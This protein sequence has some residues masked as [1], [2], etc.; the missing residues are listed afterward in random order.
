MWKTG[1]NLSSLRGNE[2][3][4]NHTLIPTTF[5]VLLSSTISLFG[6]Q[7]N[8]LGRNNQNGIPSI[9][10]LPSPQ[11]TMD[12]AWN[13]EDQISY[14]NENYTNTCGTSGLTQHP[15]LCAATR[16]IAVQSSFGVQTGSP[17]TTGIFS[18]AVLNYLTTP[19][20]NFRH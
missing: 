12:E 8:V 5:L 9:L 6:Q 2:M 14:T 11:G 18:A 1:N 20:K 10:E 7:I 4:R 13:R 17:R 3:S 16:R 19:H 15:L